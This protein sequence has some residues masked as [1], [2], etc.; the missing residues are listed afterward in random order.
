DIAN[1]DFLYVLSTFHFQ[2]IRWIERF[3]W[4]KLTENE[5][6]ASFYFWR[7][8]GRRMNIRDIPPTADAFEAWS[9]SH[10]REKF[11][12]DDAN[13]RIATATR[14]M[15]VGWAPKPLRSVVRVA[16]NSMLDDAMLTSFGFP[17]APRVVEKLVAGALRLRGRI[18]HYLPSR[19]K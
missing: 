8:V 2:P 9:L 13:K 18:L 4:R 19:K 7:E 1:D 3:G 15:F 6:Q 10:E 17:R 14:E 11:R 16:I 12:Y 5:K